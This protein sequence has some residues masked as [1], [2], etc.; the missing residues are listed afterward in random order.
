MH[1]SGMLWGYAYILNEACLVQY[2]L[3][4]DRKTFKMHDSRL[5]H[6]PL[7]VNSLANT[8]GGA[9]TSLPDPGFCCRTV[10]NVWEQHRSRGILF[11]V[12]QVPSGNVSTADGVKPN[13][14]SAFL[15]C[16]GRQANH[17]VHPWHA[18]AGTLFCISCIL[19]IV[20]TR[21]AHRQPCIQSYSSKLTIAA[22]QA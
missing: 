13:D 19:F 4:L 18:G 20:N 14:G 7:C 10:A 21:T 12:V 16:K 6:L 1:S 8:A 15:T 9:V 5:A 3:S 17:L 22:V 11:A 2:I